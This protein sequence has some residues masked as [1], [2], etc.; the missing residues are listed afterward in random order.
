M[1]RW[2]AAAAPQTTPA[3]DRIELLLARAGALAAAGRFADS[4]EALLE[5]TA[6]APEQSSA[7]CTTLTT[8]CARAEHRLG[9]YKQGPRASG[10]R[11]RW[12]A[13]TGLSRVRRAAH[14]ARA[15]RVLPVEIPVDARLGRE[16]GSRRERTWRCAPDGG[17]AGDACTHGRDD[18][19]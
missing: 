17:G 16:C 14:R 2:G 12:P 19:G 13:R 18:R 8:A 9:Q 7:L 4:H 10:A 11:S 1:V 3:E 6:I 5:A 15:Q